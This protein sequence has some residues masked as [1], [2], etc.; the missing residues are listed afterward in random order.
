[1]TLTPSGSAITLDVLVAPSDFDVSVEL[2]AFVFPV[3]VLEIIVELAFVAAGATA[4][5]LTVDGVGAAAAVGKGV[6]LSA[7]GFAVGASSSGRLRSNASASEGVCAGVL[8]ARTVGAAD[9]GRTGA[10]EANG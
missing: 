9:A 2:R 4:A 5:A 8:E 6:T 7:T 10:A 1:M 3:S